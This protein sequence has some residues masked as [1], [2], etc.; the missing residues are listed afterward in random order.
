MAP[1]NI[2]VSERS[3]IVENTHI[4]HV[5]VVDST[6]SLLFSLGDPMRMTL[7]RSAVKPYQALAILETGCFER[8]GLD[9]ADLAFICASH[10]SEQLHLDQTR[11]MLRKIGAKE[12]DIQCGGHPALM[13]EIN[14]QWAKD[15]Y[16]PG[17]RDNNCSGKHVGMIGGALSLGGDVETYH[18]A[19]SKM[20]QHTMRTIES[21]I[22]HKGL[23]GLDGCNLPAP[24]YPLNDF[25]KIY[26]TVSSASSESNDER[27]KNLARI[28]S[29]MT[30]YPELVG[31]T[32]RFCTVLMQLTGGRLVAK[33]GADACYG[34]GVR[35]C[36]A[37]EQLGAVGG[38]GIAVKIEDGNEAALY[39][40]VVE[41]MRQLALLS[42]VETEM[43][44]RFHQPVRLNTMGVPV[45]HM[46]PDFTLLR[47]V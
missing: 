28:Y 43:L 6:G 44:S 7:L 22:G 17:G 12:S 34:V 33:L 41:V 31:G 21:A 3:G 19:E 14:L 27:T 45:G 29:A 5:A 42:T 13:E 25:A 40:T 11:T 39:V 20:Q 46:K 16:K 1:R 35:A 36:R 38:L 37:T 2:V 26:A 4:P 8:Y 9:D 24:G 15:D 10:S 32:E 30:T 47:P 18:Q 23:W